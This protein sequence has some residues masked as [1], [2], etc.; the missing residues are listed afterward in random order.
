QNVLYEYQRNSERYQMV[1]WAQGA[2]DNFSVV[3]PGMGICHQVNLEY[4][5]QGVIERDGW[6]FPDSL[7]GTDSHTH[8]I[9]GIGVLG[10]GV[11]GIEA[12]AALLGQAIYFRCPRVIGLKLVG[13]LQEGITATDMVLA[14]TNALRKYGVVGDFVEVFGEGLKNLSV[15][16]R[17]TIANMSPEFGCTVTYFPIDD[18]TLEYMKMTNRNEEVIDRVEKYCKGNMLWRTGKENIE[19]TDIIELDL[20]KLEPVVAGP[21]RPQD[22][23]KVRDLEAFF[24][25]LLMEESKRE[26]VSI[27]DRREHAWFNEGGSGTQYLPFENRKSVKEVT[28]SQLRT[29]RIKNKNEEF[30]LHD[31]SIVIAAI[32]SCTN[33]SNPSVMIGAGL[34]AKKAVE[35]GLTTKPWVKTS[36]APGSKVVADYLERSG[37][38]N[39]LKS[40][41]F[42]T[43]GYGCTSCIGNSGPLPPAI[44]E[45]VAREDLV[46]TSIL[47]GNRN[48]EARVHPQVRMN[49]LA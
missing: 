14:I 20:D 35:R 12:E 42:H 39:E 19:Y 37:L 49:F 4:L 44:A 10:W 45:A 46:V 17:A 25:K 36:L 2:F 6:W 9:N 1:K 47:S 5:A 13:K 24:P 29:V 28:E 18:R 40:L 31:G 33:T 15:P 32:T 23:I 30:L 26:Y 16:D 27:D 41:K 48:F 34:V 38:L 8:M 7:V 3:P 11:G 22:E 43:V 21:K